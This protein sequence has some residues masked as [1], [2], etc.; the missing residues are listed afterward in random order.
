MGKFENK[1]KS[2]FSTEKQIHERL[3]NT[4]LVTGMI[5]CVLAT[6]ISLIFQFEIKSIYLILATF[7]ACVVSLWIANGWN[8]PVFACCLICLFI[9]LIVFPL[10]YFVSGG[11]YSGCPVWML[12]GLLITFAL[13]PGTSLT[14][15]MFLICVIGPIGTVIVGFKHPEWIIPFETDLQ[16]GVDVLNAVVLVAI[17]FG[18][19]YKIQASSYEK[20]KKELEKAAKYDKYYDDNTALF[21]QLRSSL[22]P[23]LMKD[24]EINKDE[25]R[26]LVES[27]IIVAKYYR[28][29]GLA[30]GLK[31]D[32]EVAEAV[33]VLRDKERYNG[34]LNGTVPSHA[35][36]KRKSNK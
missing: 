15:G 3:L 26:E 25:I 7:V 9:N 23:Q 10:M 2:L 32:K 34:L 33:K 8:K 36:D 11:L 17:M 27:E 35:G 18:A 29:G 12:M 13:I 5:S 16:V 21:E 1:I 28:A 24:M 19:M 14:I 22:K 31:F 20:Q 4:L 6:I 30:H